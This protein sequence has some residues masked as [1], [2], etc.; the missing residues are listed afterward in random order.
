MKI[1]I[2]EYI[3]G[4]G[5]IGEPL[6]ASLAKEGELMLN[7]IARDFLAIDDVEVCVLRDHRLQDTTQIAQEF[8]VSPEFGYGETIGTFVN[9]IDAMLIVAPETENILFNL[10][11]EYSKFD[12]ILLNCDPE[13]VALTTD[14]YQTYLHLQN[15]TIN[16]VP[17]YLL[18][19]VH[20]I[21]ASKIVAKPKDGVGCENILLLDNAKN[22][23]DYKLSN[24]YIY[25]PYIHGQHISLSLLCWGVEC[26]ILSVNHQCIAEENGT[27]VLERC[28]VNCLPRDLFYEFTYQLISAISGLKGYVGVDLLIAKD[29]IYLVEINPRLTT[30]YVGIRTALGFNPGRLFLQ[31][32]LDK[33]LAKF[34][35][36]K[37]SNS[38]V[39][40]IGDVCAA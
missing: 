30:T 19:E 40:D 3:T 22:I 11:V 32:F 8:I 34:K 15:F 6:P 17:T 13:S 23:R 14:K 26:S 24:N 20:K 21:T 16:Q 27:L 38:V 35:Q 5:M 33:K 31:T 36:N 7:A 39:V 18:S 4:G 1:L 2:F 37:K 28:I 12:F 10:C 29:K 25:Q 9:E